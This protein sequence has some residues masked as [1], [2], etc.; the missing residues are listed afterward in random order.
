MGVEFSGEVLSAGQSAQSTFQKGQPVFGLALGGAY[1]QVIKVQ[2]SLLLHKPDKLSWEQAAAIPEQWL[3]AFQALRPLA[4]LQPKESVLIHAGA[5][6]VGLA[7]AQLAK[8]FGAA[9]VYVTAGSEDK[10]KMCESI[11]ADRA[12]NYKAQDWAEE[13]SKA[14]NGEGVDVIMD[15]I[16]ANYWNNNINSLKRD[17]RLIMQG[18]MGGVKVK[19]GA[20]FKRLRIIGSTL[21]SRT[22][23]YQGQLVQDFLKVS[24]SLMWPK[25]SLYADNYAF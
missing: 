12:F 1:A 23:E 13:L 8:D 9:K 16:G 4:N 14:T 3:T 7:A 6:G 21:R 18:A 10:C 2:S 5:S 19:D 17:G 15:F 11:A 24:S 22:V 25:R 20:F